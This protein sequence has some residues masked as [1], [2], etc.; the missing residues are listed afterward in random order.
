MEICQIEIFAQLFLQCF[1]AIGK[2]RAVGVVPTPDA[3]R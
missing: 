1:G 3:R 2:R